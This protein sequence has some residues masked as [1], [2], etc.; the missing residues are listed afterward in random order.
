[1]RRITV[2]NRRAALALSATTAAS[3][4]LGILLWLA[5]GQ[6]AHRAALATA[7]RLV[8]SGHDEEATRLL[9][10]LLRTL[11]KDR[12]TLRLLAKVSARRI[13][14]DKR[15]DSVDQLLRATAFNEDL[16]RQLEGVRDVRSGEVQEVRKR[17]VGL[18]VLHGELIQAMP[19]SRSAPELGRE[20]PF[21]LALRLAEQAVDEEIGQA[22]REGRKSI[23]PVVC[24]LEA[25]A[26]EGLLT[27]NA[28]DKDVKFV[29]DAY[30][31]ALL[32]GEIK[33]SALQPEREG[34]CD[35]DPT[36]NLSAAR[37][38]NLLLAR[39]RR[40]DA[41]EVF[42]K[43]ERLNPDSASIHLL[44]HSI[45]RNMASRGRATARPADAPQVLLD[46][47]RASA[48]LKMALEAV[49]NDPNVARYV[50]LAAAEDAL[51][52]GNA[53]EARKYISQVPA[54]RRGGDMQVALLEGLVSLVEERPL[55]A[56]DVW[57]RGLV[58]TGG[59]NVQLTWW[60]AYVQLQAG[61]VAEAGR[62]AEQ[63]R[64]LKGA[65][66]KDPLYQILQAGLDLHAG[67]PERALAI[68][69]PLR[70]AN[71]T[72]LEKEHDARVR[73]EL[74]MAQAYENLR[75]PA[76]AQAAC[77]RAVELAPDATEP[78]IARAR[79]L[80]RRDPQRAALDLQ[81]ALDK[82]HGD[83]GL[84]TSLAS[85][86]EEWMARLP[87]ARR[88]FGKL[89]DVLRRARE[90]NPES[91]TLVLLRANRLLLDDQPEAA[92]DLLS[93]T[94]R[95]L[96]QQ[97]AP[98]DVARA[99]SKDNE[100]L[101]TAYVEGLA[102]LG[103]DE[104][105]DRVLELGS[106]PWNFGDRVSLRTAR[107]ERLLARGRG[108][109]A[110][111]LLESDW[112]HLGTTDQAQLAEAAGRLRLSQGDIGGAS[113]AFTTWARLVPQNLQPRLV[114][115]DLALFTGEDELARDILKGLKAQ[116]GAGATGPDKQSIT[117]PLADAALQLHEIE[118]PTY[119][120]S[121]EDRRTRLERV[122]GSLNEAARAQGD[123]LPLYALLLGRLEELRG[124]I[125]KAMAA[126][127]AAW[128]DG[129]GTP[130]AF[131][132]L[133]SLLAR[134][135][136][137]NERALERLRA[138]LSGGVGDTLAIALVRATTD[139]DSIARLAREAT[140]A[141][142]TAMARRLEWAKRF[143]QF[144]QL[145]QAEEAFRELVD[146]SPETPDTWLELVRVQALRGEAT[147][148]TI[149]R[150]QRAVVTDRPDLFEAQCLW[151]GRD[152]VA[153][154]RAFRRFLERHPDDPDALQDAALFAREGGELERA[155]GYLRRVREL[156][157]DRRQATLD[158]ASCLS[159][160]PGGASWE[161]AWAVL[162]PERPD[163][164]LDER[165]ARTLVLSR[166][167]SPSRKA[168]AVPVLEALLADL[169]GNDP[170][171]T[172]V[173]KLL[174]R[175]Y[176]AARQP[177]RAREMI[178]PVVLTSDDPAALALSVESLIA[179]GL[180]DEAERQVRRLG[181]LQ[182][183]NEQ[184]ARLRAA[185]LTGRAGAASANQALI[186]AISE[187]LATGPPAH[188]VPLARLAFNYF[189]TVNP[190]ALDDA[191][192]VARLMTSKVPDTAWMTAMLLARRG[193]ADQALALCLD[194]VKAAGGKA[195]VDVASVA[196]EIALAPHATSDQ[197]DRAGSVI[198][199]ARSRAPAEADLI[200]IA[201]TMMH[202]QGEYDEAARSYRQA[203]ELD[204]KNPVAQANLAWLLSEILGQPDEALK[205]ID[206]L[207]AQ[208]GRYPR[209]I[210]V[211]G[212]ILLRLNRLDEAIHEFEEATRALNIG[213]FYYHLAL[214]HHKA[215]HEAEFRK[216][217]DQ[218]RRM[219]IDP[220][221]VD[222]AERKG[223]TALM[224]QP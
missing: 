79:F 65:T 193:Q 189:L 76:E 218:V 224:G 61:Q 22:E 212:I 172:V 168:R 217:R 56:V 108:R 221:E 133:V 83:F 201:A 190:P 5:Q 197:W 204:P 136:L 123:N 98:A 129:Q 68:L 73:V 135:P 181:Q 165:L 1:M 13:L 141:S 48:E 119:R 115:F 104:E 25:M 46:E 151:L 184:V 131:P 69:V 80:K 206:S 169:P 49:T 105:A 19:L 149:A 99:L 90:I 24:R 186:G 51:R 31:T 62:L 89:D 199:I 71:V 130:A 8:D 178:L 28:S 55:E 14:V 77:D 47:E 150:A 75:R 152:R 88:E 43:L 64:R 155:I 70:T 208:M 203:L 215:G 45:Y 159:E 114:L 161:E 72:A 163:E 157:P 120:G 81:E 167:P 82:R 210:D 94:L 191:E 209:I 124:D 106:R 128:G 207:I 113:K 16:L 58:E 170:R 40:P 194:A 107:A 27:A 162:G 92:V 179:Q 140:K 112:Q 36:D 32:G 213:T 195:L 17:L 173:R 220:S 37:L 144:G 156:A 142:G 175:E 196:G 57:Q 171:M 139:R 110:Q 84:L 7:E 3:L 96:L 174:A 116:D 85:T 10:Q 143:L 160:L 148:A 20:D 100:L 91:P 180:W 21:P 103:R 164:T 2:L 198:G 93:H 125:P 121:P 182:P 44:G 202:R 183:G 177:G 6:R 127:Q 137:A 41:E 29:V 50:A 38:M 216:A 33:S 223:F 192:K 122:A 154:D 12:E 158:L 188:A 101:L 86:M 63:Y 34:Y 222:P 126:Y 187:D 176:M 30:K 117:V 26:R 9:D 145:E 147:A 52:R 87:K 42:E 53:P 4:L 95:S 35:G 67:L 200:V 97:E 18:Y 111:A 211:R 23:D 15:I 219:R 11:P 66:A 54:E 118:S 214:A 146:E 153:A 134:E 166:A 205:R 185:L 78:R 74:L 59:T 102:R 138:Q 132:R 60:L 109:D 39:G